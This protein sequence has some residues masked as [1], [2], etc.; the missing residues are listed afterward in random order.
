MPARSSS[1]RSTPRLLTLAVDLVVFTPR[2]SELAVLVAPVATTTRSRARD[3]WALPSDSLR[4][5]E[6][7]D[8]AAA[9]IA[10]DILGA[11]PS[12]LDQAG[13]RGGATHQPSGPNVSVTYFGLAPDSGSVR[14]QAEWV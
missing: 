3:R 7:L 10:R 1:A 2:E 4:S 5:D 13:A 6:S 8:D 11:P 14:R 9:R 12:L